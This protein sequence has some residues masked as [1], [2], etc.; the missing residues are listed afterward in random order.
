[1]KRIPT[2][3]GPFPTRLYFDDDEIEQ[4]CSKALAET[5]LLPDKPGPIRIDRFIENKFNVRI[6][7]EDLEKGVLGFTEFSPTGVEAVHIAEPNGDLWIQQDRRVNSTL[8]H[9]AGHCLMH[10]E[11]FIEHFA[12]HKAF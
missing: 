9:E 12:N 11:L 2:P 6:I 1:M 5:N 4:L 10:T 3:E 7:Y 8:A